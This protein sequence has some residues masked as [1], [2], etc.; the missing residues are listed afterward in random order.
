[1]HC[2]YQIIESPFVLT[3]RRVAAFKYYI[4]KA[5]YYFNHFADDQPIGLL[6]SSPITVTFTVSRVLTWCWA[7]CTADTPRGHSHQFIIAPGPILVHY[8]N[9]SFSF[10]I[11]FMKTSQFFWWFLPWWPGGRRYLPGRNPYA[12]HQH[13]SFV[14]WSE[15]TSTEYPWCRLR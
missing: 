9:A 3:L 8:S 15:R 4:L 5:C 11:M 6:F 1:M 2:T 13:R 14:Q 7:L 12:N 10:Y